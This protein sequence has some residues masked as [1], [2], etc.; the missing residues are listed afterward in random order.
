M[1]EIKYILLVKYSSKGK[2]DYYLGN[3]YKKYIKEVSGE[4]GARIIL[5]NTFIASKVCL[6]KFLRR[7]Y[8]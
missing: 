5:L 7:M 8:W 4:L 2:S 1:K 6:D 3:Y